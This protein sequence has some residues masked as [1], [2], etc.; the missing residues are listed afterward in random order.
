MTLSEQQGAPNSTYVR[1][2]IRIRDTYIHT[3]GSDNNAGDF[4]TC[5]FAKSMHANS[6]GMRLIKG[7]W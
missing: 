6:A 5:V 1:T 2:T 4:G 3:Y 7:W